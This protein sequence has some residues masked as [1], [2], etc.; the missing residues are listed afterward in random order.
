MVQTK[1]GATRSETSRRA[2]LQ[3]AAALIE[4]SGFDRVSI[5]GIASEAGVG[6]QTIY[7]WYPSKSAIIAEC[8]VEGIL[9]AERF[10]IPDT[11][12]V[13]ADLAHWLD[14]V[15]K[16]VADDSNRVLLT[17]LLVAAAQ[18]PEITS[19]LAERLG[20]T[21]PPFA[22]RVEAAH[23]AGELRGEAHPALVGEALF[24]SIA[25]RILGRTSYVAGEARAM[26]DFLLGR[27]A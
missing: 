3:A 12:D 4:H 22:H 24:G 19:G 9:V 14:A 16:Y 26:V 17:S 10:D 25:V 8:L 21:A 15:Y 18:S 7:R 13:F 20:A 27:A 11:G 2:I 1:R 6:K 23:D 5:E